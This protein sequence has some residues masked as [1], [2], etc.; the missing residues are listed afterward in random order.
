MDD[1]FRKRFAGFVGLCLILG[2]IVFS[3]RGQFCLG[4]KCHFKVGDAD[5]AA[6][7]GIPTNVSVY[8]LARD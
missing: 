5:E 4:A 7:A 3:A 6:L 1:N 8:L 2:G